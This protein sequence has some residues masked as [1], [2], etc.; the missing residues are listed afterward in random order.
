MSSTGHTTLSRSNLQSITDALG[1]YARRMG[2]DFSQNPFADELQRS[3]TPNAILELLQ[4]RE[5]EFIKYREG[6]RTLINCFSPA[7]R[8]LQAFSGMLSEAVSLVSCTITV[9]IHFY[10]NVASLS[11]RQRLSS[12]E[13]MFS[14][15]YV[16]LTLSSTISLVTHGHVR[17]SVKSAQIM[18]LS[19][20]S[21]SRWAIS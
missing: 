8:V 5:K 19:S 1:D 20:T 21:S 6:N 15:P 14:L 17:P 18:M 11:P 10:L 9:L 16:C 13:S 2:I 4:Q 12:L 3:N 7:V